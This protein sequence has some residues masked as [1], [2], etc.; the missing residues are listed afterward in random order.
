L[1]PEYGLIWAAEPPQ[2]RCSEFTQDSS[3]GLGPQCGYKGFG[4]PERAELISPLVTAWNDQAEPHT[5]NGLLLIQ[6]ARQ[7]RARLARCGMALLL[8]F[9]SP[10]SIGP[11]SSR[12][13]LREPTCSTPRHSGTGE[14]VL[15]PCWY[16]APPRF[17]GSNLKECCEQ[18]KDVHR[19]GTFG[20]MVDATLV[21]ARVPPCAS[22]AA[23]M[24]CQFQCCT[25][26]VGRAPGAGTNRDTLPNGAPHVGFVAM[27][28]N[29][30]YCQPISL[31]SAQCGPAGYFMRSR[32]MQSAILQQGKLGAA[33]RE[34]RLSGWAL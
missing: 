27:G 2:A 19:P 14:P 26:S 24:I 11:R 25:A 32:V 17:G 30:F 29:P 16:G 1:A 4:A 3:G 31:C 7:S 9:G 20:R 6:P 13:V 5:V 34:S 28:A 18:H 8:V 10:S 12:W 23:W 33:G 21:Q 15:R 22:G